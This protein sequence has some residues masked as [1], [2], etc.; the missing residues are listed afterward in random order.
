MRQQYIDLRQPEYYSEINQSWW[1]DQ[2]W[3]YNRNCN[4]TYSNSKKILVLI[5]YNDYNKKLN[6]CY[7]PFIY[8]DI[9]IVL[10]QYE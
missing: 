10:S 2:P 3:E 9:K 5:H 6:I 7:L 8:K 4:L 1:Y